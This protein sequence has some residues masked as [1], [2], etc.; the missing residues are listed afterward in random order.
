MRI[1]RATD[2]ATYG[3]LVDADGEPVDW[4]AEERR[5]T[6][7]EYLQAI[8]EDEVIGEPIDLI[9]PERFRKSHQEGIHRVSSGGETHVIGKT[10]ELAAINKDGTEFPVELSLATWFLDD[11]R[12]YTGIIRDISER[13]QAEQKFR[14]VTESAVDAIISADHTGNIISWNKAATH[15]LGYTEEEAVG[16]RLELIIPEQYHEAHRNG[17][18][19]FTET[20]EAVEGDPQHSYGNIERAGF[21][22]IGP[23]TLDYRF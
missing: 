3:E 17:M 15:V 9:I 22:K 23:R 6:D 2:F 13:K 16:Q 20:G 11:E 8:T 10:V 7:P 4:E 19:R 14:S 1:A 12:Y 5:S 21:K 18:A